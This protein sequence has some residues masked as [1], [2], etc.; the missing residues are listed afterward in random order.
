MDEQDFDRKNKHLTSYR[1]VC[2]ATGYN[3]VRSGNNNILSHN[4]RFLTP[5]LYFLRPEENQ[6]SSDYDCPGLD[7]VVGCWCRRDLCCRIRVFA[8]GDARSGERGGQRHH[9]YRRRCVASAIIVAWLATAAAAAASGAGR[10]R[11]ER[12][13]GPDTSAPA[14]VF[15]LR[16]LQRRGSHERTGSDVLEKLSVFFETTGT[17]RLKY[18]GRPSNNEQNSILSFTFNVG[19][20]VDKEFY[21]DLNERCVSSALIRKRGS[22][23]TVFLHC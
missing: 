5:P 10:G 8:G 14:A 6:L 19:Q 2:C 11:G 16:S 15:Y 4:V 18:I 7:N 17:T 13:R 21:S 3:L 23:Y 9:C 12:R 20:G 22:V 1:M